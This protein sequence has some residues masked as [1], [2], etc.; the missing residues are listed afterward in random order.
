[1]T[2]VALHLVLREKSFAT[3]FAELIKNQG[4]TGQSRTSRRNGPKLKNC[5]F[6]VVVATVQISNYFLSDLYLIADL[7]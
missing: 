3:Y 5:L 6:F 2:T 4:K 1:M 7:D